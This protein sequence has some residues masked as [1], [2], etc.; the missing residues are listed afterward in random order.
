MRSA[1][2]GGAGALRGIGRP[3]DWWPLAD[4]DPV[5][6]DP[7]AIRQEAA[8]MRRFAQALRD[9]AGDLRAIAAGEGLK[10]KYADALRDNASELEFHLRQTAERYEHVYGHLTSWAGEL[11]DFQATSFGLLRQAWDL[12]PAGQAPVPAPVPAPAPAA[13]DQDD[14][15][16]A[17]RQ[18]LAGLTN[19]RDDRAVVYAGRIKRSC[20]DVIK[21]SPWESFENEADAV[22]DSDWFG[23]VFEAAS[24]VV[25]F[26]GIATLFLNPAAWVVD[27]ALGLSIVLAAK[28]VLAMSVGEGSWFDIGMDVIGFA[29]MAT[30]VTAFKALTKIKDATKIAAKAAAA[31]QAVENVLDESRSALGR[32]YRVTSR[33]NSSGSAKADAR[34]VRRGI[35]ATAERAGRAAGQAEAERVGPEATQREALA[36]GGD[37]EAATVCH[38]ID[39]M[40]GAYA[41]HDAVWKASAGANSWKVGFKASWMVGAGSDG[42]DKMLGKSDLAPRKPSFKPY[43][44]FKDRFSS[45]I[46]TGW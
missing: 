5:P 22:L 4:R 43:N 14:P 8:S 15:L 24:W 18:R 38:E 7:D 46:G 21:D 36:F 16:E 9:Q 2:V 11:E 12:P 20:D 25:T 1:P 37:R 28:D 13:G 42:F 33:V 40:R 31:E 3:H 44:D 17:L 6:G 19:H 10:G 35:L 45:V 34:R 39:R 41:N 32:T 23:R 26:V 29:T 27:L 30:G